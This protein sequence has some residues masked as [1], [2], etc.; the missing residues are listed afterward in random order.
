MFSRVSFAA[1]V[2]VLLGTTS[3]DAAP[4]TVPSSGDAGTVFPR[5]GTTDMQGPQLVSIGF[6]PTSIDVTNGAETVEVTAHVT[7]D[8]AGVRSVQPSFAR[9]S[10]NHT[11]S[12]PL[13]R[14]TGTSTDGIYVGS[15]AVPQ[16]AESG[17]WTMRQVVLFDVVDNRRDYYSYQ[18]PMYPPGT[19]TD[20]SVRGTTP[21]RT[22]APT[23]L[24]NISTRLSVETGDNVLIG[25]FIR[26]G[27]TAEESDRA[28]DRTFA[29]RCLG[30]WRIRR[31][32]FMAPRD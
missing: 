3:P 20:L 11:V 26:H 8:I 2:S 27:H 16:G 15:V 23:T 9:P 18:P 17:G 10:G 7:D 14:V 21:A 5:T 6:T 30:N 22:P 28:R 12:G 13:A 19:P 32:S 25:G 24:G 1:V 31:S 29:C 4:L